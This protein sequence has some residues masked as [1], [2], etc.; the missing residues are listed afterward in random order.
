MKAKRFCCVCRCSNPLHVRAVYRNPFYREM[1]MTDEIASISGRNSI[2]EFGMLSNAIS[3]LA[4][5]GILIQQQTL[6][7]AHND[8]VHAH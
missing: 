3:V 2:S 4:K 7:K 1:E 5:G 8:H 6:I